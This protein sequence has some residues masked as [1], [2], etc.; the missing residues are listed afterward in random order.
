MHAPTKSGPRDRCGSMILMGSFNRISF[1]AEKG[2]ICFFQRH[3]IKINQQE[4]R[5]IIQGMIGLF[6]Y[7]AYLIIKNAKPK[8]IDALCD[9]MMR[10]SGDI[11]GLKQRRI[12][13]N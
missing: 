5:H 10:F 3:K 9:D 8:E 13:M 12:R 11:R 1:P 6:G 2:G 7:A 4:A